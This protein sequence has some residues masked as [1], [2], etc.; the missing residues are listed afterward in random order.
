MQQKRYLGFYLL[1][2]PLPA[3]PLCDFLIAE[4]PTFTT[5]PFRRHQAESNFMLP[6]S[7]QLQ[8]PSTFWRIFFTLI[9]CL[10]CH[11]T[12]RECQFLI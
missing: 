2:A 3:L 6:I 12:K 8:F 7:S 9:K 5:L 10:Q 11:K 1:I 4:Y